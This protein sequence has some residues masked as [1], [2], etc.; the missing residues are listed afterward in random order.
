MKWFWTSWN[1]SF[2]VCA[3]SHFDSSIT[4]IILT[5]DMPD[6]ESCSISYDVDCWWFELHRTC[7]IWSLNVF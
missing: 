5:L 3:R 7:P 6:I 1:F 2:W 4:K